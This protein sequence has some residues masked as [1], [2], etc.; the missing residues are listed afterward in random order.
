MSKRRGRHP[1]DALKRATP[2]S[3]TKPGSW[4]CDGNGLYL[5]TDRSGNKRWI[6]RLVTQGVRRD[7]A[8]GSVAL[9][10]LDEAREQAR[11]LRRIAR[12]DGGDPRNELR[13]ARMD[14]PSFEEATRR[15]HA[16]RVGAGNTKTTKACTAGNGSPRWRNTPSP[17]SAGCG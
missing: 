11:R 15:V 5:V 14:I 4:R 1:H 9:V 13:R 17:I 16:A 6:Q 7:L 3:R 8:L 12:K 10:S 2:A